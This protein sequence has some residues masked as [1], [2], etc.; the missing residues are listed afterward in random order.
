MVL[1]RGGYY[2]NPT[3]LLACDPFFSRASL[4]ILSSCSFYFPTTM[5]LM[6]CYGSAFHVNKLG[7]KKTADVSNFASSKESDATPMEKVSRD[8]TK[9][10]KKL[11]LFFLKLNTERKNSLEENWRSRTGSLSPGAGPYNILC[12]GIFFF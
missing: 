4:R 10:W 6:Y 11:D 5:I 2:F 1:P 7:L 12:K 8:L 3:G 9:R